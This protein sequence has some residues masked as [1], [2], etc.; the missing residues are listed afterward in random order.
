MP[1]YIEMMKE[2]SFFVSEML[3]GRYLL[4]KPAD[5][6]EKT[7]KKKWK[8][9]SGEILSDL[10]RAFESIEDFNAET[11]HDTFKSHL[12]AKEIGMGAVLP[13]LRVSVTGKG[14]GPSMFDIMAF[15]GKE[16]SVSR[17]R[18]GVQKL[19]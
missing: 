12:E 3:E 5:F 18:E 19:G 1:A 11:T 9:N 6:D 17:I 15:L 8:A 4:E 2:R 16:E 14:A 7:I 13:V 10:A